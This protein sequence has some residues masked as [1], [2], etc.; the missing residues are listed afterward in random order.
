MNWHETMIFQQ[1]VILAI[2]NRYKDIESSA[3]C[4]FRMSLY[5]LFVGLST[6]KFHVYCILFVFFKVGNRNRRH[7]TIPSVFHAHQLKSQLIS[8][9]LIYWVRGNKSVYIACSQ[10]QII[11]PG[12]SSNC[13]IKLFNHQYFACMLVFNRLMNINKGPRIISNN[14]ITQLQ[15]VIYIYKQNVERRFKYLKPV[16]CCTLNIKHSTLIAGTH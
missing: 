6:F 14:L 5:V 3:K 11:P 16:N 10:H 4:A 12:T 9:S 13:C 7:C 8:R 1:G 2:I 15:L